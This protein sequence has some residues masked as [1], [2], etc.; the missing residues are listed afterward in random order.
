VFALYKCTFTYLLLGNGCYTQ[1]MKC[2]KLDGVSGEADATGV[3]RTPRLL[4][5]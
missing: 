3:K 5:F 1:C 2:Q 4:P